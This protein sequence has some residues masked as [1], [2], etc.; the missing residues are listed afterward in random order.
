MLGGA[1][2]GVVVLVVLV[3]V[4]FVF[5]DKARPAWEE[6]VA[7]TAKDELIQARAACQAAV[8]ADPNSKSGLKAAGKL[9]VLNPLA[10][11][12]EAKN[13]ATKEARTR[14]CKSKKYVTRC[15]YKGEPRPTLLDGPTLSQCNQDA[16]QLR[17][18]IG[19]IC[20]SCVCADDFV[21]DKKDEE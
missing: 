12:L 18:T 20:P 7:L 4:L 9:E 13:K 21:D 8:Q 11:E 16:H 1:G 19:M 5:R 15:I 3:L 6:C 17:Q 14:P 10:D 2:V